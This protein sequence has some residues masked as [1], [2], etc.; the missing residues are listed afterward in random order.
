MFL[1]LPFFLCFPLALIGYRTREREK[2]VQSVHYSSV[3]AKMYPST[4]SSLNSSKYTPEQLVALEACYEK[5]PTP[6][7]QAVKDLAAET[8]LTQA[9]C[10]AWLQY[11]RK[12]RKKHLMEHE[13][14]VFRIEIKCLNER[15]GNV[16]EQNNRLHIE[17]QRLR[18]AYDS[19]KQYEKELDKATTTLLAQKATEDRS[20]K[21][22]QPPPAAAAKA[23]AKEGYREVQD[24]VAAAVD[25]E[26]GRKKRPEE[27]ADTTTTLDK[28]AMTLAGVL[29]RRVEDISEQTH[30]L[31]SIPLPGPS[32]LQGQATAT[33][34]TKDSDFDPHHPRVT[35][36]TPDAYHSSTAGR[37]GRWHA[38]WGR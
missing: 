2:Q 14:E 19:M 25:K 9:Q 27:D 28:A 23:E 8:G 10:R 26:E 6:S 34:T 5:N 4:S 1:F 11:Q 12:K 32:E 3:R 20:I 22:E 29:T 13:R 35:M 30:A 16:K 24:Q 37:T 33:P 17:N 36:P 38:L 18:K 15:I 7:S 31:S 21:G